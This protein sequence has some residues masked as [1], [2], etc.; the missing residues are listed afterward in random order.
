MIR[1]PTR[2]A[3]PLALGLLLGAAASCHAATDPADRVLTLEVAP[4]LAPCIALIP[5]E[6]LQV[7]ERADGPWQLFYAEIV[8][9]TYEPGYMYVLR[10]AQRDVPNPPA[11]GSSAEYQLLAVLSRTAVGP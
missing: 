1:P 10:V 5:R 2:R 9:F 7:R 8:G 6:C 3:R 4:A 11:D